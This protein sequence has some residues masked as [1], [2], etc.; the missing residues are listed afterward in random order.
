VAL[1]LELARAAHGAVLLSETYSELFSARMGCQKFQP[2]YYG[3]DIAA[4][5]LREDD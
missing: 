3:V 5:C 1:D 2:L 4:L